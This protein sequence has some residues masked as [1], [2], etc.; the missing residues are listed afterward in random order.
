[1]SGS[2][3]VPVCRSDI[4]SRFSPQAMAQLHE[5]LRSIDW[6]SPELV[7]HQPS[8]ACLLAELLTAAGVLP[9]LS[10]LASTCHVLLVL[11]APSCSHTRMLSSCSAFPCL[12]QGAHVHAARNLHWSCTKL[13]SAS[14]CRASQARWNLHLHHPLSPL[15]RAYPTCAVEKRQKSNPMRLATWPSSLA[16]STG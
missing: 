9:A 10:S 5:Q 13:D 3:T 1:M 8:A 6:Q 14:C 11:S 2:H 7:S 4:V 15:A 12:H 16:T